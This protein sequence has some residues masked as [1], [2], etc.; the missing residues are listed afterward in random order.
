MNFIKLELAAFATFVKGW[1]AYIF[2]E[3]PVIGAFVVG[4]GI[5]MLFV[6]GIKSGMEQAFKM[7]GMV[8]G[9][10]VFLLLFVHY[11]NSLFFHWFPA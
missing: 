5:I 4:L 6:Y 1:F 8:I 10:I 11:L 7:T 2:P 9:G 3:Y